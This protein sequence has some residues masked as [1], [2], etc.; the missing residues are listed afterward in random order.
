[1]IH[2]LSYFDFYVAPFEKPL[3]A[4]HLAWTVARYFHPSVNS[5]TARE[6][7]DPHLAILDEQ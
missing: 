5:G 2:L 1:M 3:A 7:A 6:V 4:Q